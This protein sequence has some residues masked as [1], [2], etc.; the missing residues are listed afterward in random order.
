[1]AVMAEF[2]WRG[3]NVALPEVDV[4]DDVFVV[5]DEGG[6]LSR[7]QVKTANAR[8]QQGS[9]SAQFRVSLEQLRTLRTPDLVYVFALRN[10]SLWGPFVV[11]ARNALRTFHE[12]GN[13]GSV[14]GAHVT[15]R[16]IYTDSAVRCGSQDLS[17][18][19]NDWSRWPILPH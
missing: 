7:S 18:F 5:K 19:R 13:F 17:G 9:L 15:L 12:T 1:M 8:A 10:E 4:G 2:L 6:D 16:F 14:S 11:M 3:W